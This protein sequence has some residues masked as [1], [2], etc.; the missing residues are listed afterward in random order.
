MDWPTEIAARIKWCEFFIMLISKDGLNS[1][2]V[3]TEI[4]L[5]YLRNKREGIPKLL[6]VRVCYF[7][8][9]DYELDSYLSRIQYTR[10][11]SSVD[12]AR[13]ISELL[14]VIEQPRTPEV[15]GAEW[16]EQEQDPAIAVD[17]ADDYRRPQPVVDQRVFNAP[18]GNI[19]LDD[20]FYIT[21]T[22][23][24]II[25]QRARQ[26]GE[27]L[28]IK[29]PRQMGKSSLL[30]R[31]LAT[32]LDHGKRVGL[33]DFSG[34]TDVELEIFTNILTEIGT[35]LMRTFHI[36]RDGL[37]QIANQR[38]LTYF[39]EDVVLQDVSEPIVL[40]F[41]EVDRV[42]G[43]SYQRDFFS[44]LR[45]WHNKRAEPRSPWVRVDLALVISTEPGLL[46][47]SAERSP[48]NVTPPVVV[49]P[50]TR[51]QYS[52]LNGR[53]GSPLSSPELDQLFDLLGGHPYLTRLAFYQLIATNTWAFATMLQSAADDY[54]PFGDHLRAWL[55]KLRCHEE[56]LNELRN[57]VHNGT[58]LHEDI[59]FRLY[60]AGLVRRSGGRV[61]P[62]NLLYH[63]FFR[64]V[65]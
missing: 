53:Y 55:L 32:S 1:E 18:G 4:R 11:E 16:S 44:M 9:L 64:R 63:Q 33:L 58:I 38:D 21:R 57:I 27:T 49:D 46:I 28:V 60:G 56:L 35:F 24:V 20:P 39:I 13:L 6:P 62:A 47:D 36:Q 23:D 48:F 50:F 54:G 29:A 26:S 31:Y 2:M 30:L 52:E 45:M 12:S 8:A 5:A 41:D 10:W 19:K 7:G 65:L 43:K 22:C 25:S 34:F 51:T 3:Q 42:M 15:I 14:M 40:S 37:L 59:F 61:H 17:H